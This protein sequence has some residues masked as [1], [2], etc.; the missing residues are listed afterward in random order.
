M[1]RPEP[2]TGMW[3]GSVAT[4]KTNTAPETRA[5]EKHGP[6]LPFLSFLRT[7]YVC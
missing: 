4:G 2:E 3:G 1:A 7:G 5:A 6:R